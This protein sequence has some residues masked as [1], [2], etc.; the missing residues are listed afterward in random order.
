MLY[1]VKKHRDW[2]DR[3]TDR[4]KVLDV[5]R[6]LEGAIQSFVEAKIKTVGKDA[7][8]KGVQSNAAIATISV[9]STVLRIVMGK[10]DESKDFF[11]DGRKEIRPD[12][13]KFQLSIRARVTAVAIFVE[14]L[15]KDDAKLF[16]N[17]K[18][19]QFLRGFSFF[20]HVWDEE[21]AFKDGIFAVRPIKVQ[22][23]KN[24]LLSEAT[25]PSIEKKMKDAMD[26]LYNAFDVKFGENI[27]DNRKKH[28]CKA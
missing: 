11:W 15:E 21:S 19:N 13:D 10:E 23:L 12:N 28:H 5:H 17:K 1:E 7:V 6:L 20:D 14:R 4:S 9:C 27:D 3:I 25:N 26:M 16:N 2:L 22:D 8:S 18:S 24:H